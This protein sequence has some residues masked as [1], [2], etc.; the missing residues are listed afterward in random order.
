MVPGKEGLR[1]ILLALAE[2][3]GLEPTEYFEKILNAKDR[4]GVGVGCP[5]DRDNPERYCI[6]DLCKSDI[7][8]NKTCHCQ[9]WCKK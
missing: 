5:C 1:K 9:M 2:K 4:F 6:S 3:N 7:E 8:K